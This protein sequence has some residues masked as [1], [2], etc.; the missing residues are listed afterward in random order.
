MHSGITHVSVAAN[1]SGDD[2]RRGDD[3]DGDPQRTGVMA[4]VDALLADDSFAALGRNRNRVAMIE[5]ANA[6]GGASAARMKLVPVRALLADPPRLPGA[7]EA[8]DAIEV[9]F[10]EGV[11]PNGLPPVTTTTNKDATAPPRA[12][13]LDRSADRGGARP[14]AGATAGGV[15]ASAA[16]R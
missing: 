15:A 4:E 11:P 10:R 7:D 6:V 12:A 3:G 8:I 13:S 9:R 2:S 14:A 16:G 1:T 5:R